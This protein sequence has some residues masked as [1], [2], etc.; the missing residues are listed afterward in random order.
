M[1]SNLDQIKICRQCHVIYKKISQKFCGN[2]CQNKPPYFIEGK[3]NTKIEHRE[4]I[5]LNNAEKSIRWVCVHCKKEYSTDTMQEKD[6]I[7]DCGI[8]NDFY[9]FT[10]KTCS[11]EDCKSNG[12]YHSL[13]I[14]AKVCDLCGKSDFTL[15]GTKKIGELI[16][17]VLYLPENTDEGSWGLENFEFFEDLS[18]ERKNK[19]L[20][21]ITF[22]ILNNNLKY[23]LFGQGKS[24]TMYD[25]IRDANGFTPD[26]IYEKL[27]EKYPEEAVMF[28][29]SYEEENEV[30]FL[31]SMMALKQF[32]LNSR[33][34]PK[35]DSIIQEAGKK[36]PLPEGKLIELRGGIFKIHVWVY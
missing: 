35:A 23:L 26:S 11:N 32:E 6:Y 24:I 29:I 16:P 30:F 3:K 7:C 10:F 34:K 1:S 12:D 2:G 13:P 27:L 21:S 22:T 19:N 5:L 36:F 17:N 20:P 15:N 4:I 14:E 8:Q 33:F 28:E 31:E 18:H 9:P 25:I